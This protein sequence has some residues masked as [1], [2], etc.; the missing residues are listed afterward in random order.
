VQ[1]SGKASELLALIL[2]EK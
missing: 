1:I 2:T